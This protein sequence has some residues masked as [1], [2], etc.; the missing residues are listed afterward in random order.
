[1]GNG[2][3]MYTG[4]RDADPNDITEQDIQK[5]KQNDP[6][7]MNFA[8]ARNDIKLIMELIKKEKIQTIDDLETW[9]YGGSWFN[10]T[11]TTGSTAVVQAMYGKRA[12][13][14]V[15]REHTLFSLLKKS[16]LDNFWVESNYPRIIR[17]C[18]LHN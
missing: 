5:M 13:D 6:S 15:N 1:M 4:I 3:G 11:V 10:K 8:S 14:Q 18:R 16:C 12:W 9:C 2:K 17:H 7:H